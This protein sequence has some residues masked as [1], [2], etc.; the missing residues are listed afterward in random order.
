MPSYLHRSGARCDGARWNGGE[1]A[2]A[3]RCHPE[4]DGQDLE[5]NGAYRT[6]ASD[7]DRMRS[8][9]IRSFKF[10]AKH[11]TVLESQHG[12]AREVETSDEGA[13]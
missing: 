7:T 9:R 8:R 4:T 11:H 5:R 3:D 12:V 13:K 10:L 1:W 6:I 2:M